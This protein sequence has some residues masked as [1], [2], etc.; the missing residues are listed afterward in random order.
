MDH[1]SLHMLA[2]AHDYAEAFIR[3]SNATAVAANAYMK[4]ALVIHRH[5][6]DGSQAN[7][8]EMR[9]SLIECD[10]NE[11]RVLALFEEMKQQERF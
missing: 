8:D 2:K 4:A 1:D 3:L 11:K 5:A 6:L 9:A 7:L 10:S